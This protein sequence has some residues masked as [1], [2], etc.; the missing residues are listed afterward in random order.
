MKR[1]S[2]IIS[3][4]ILMLALCSETFA[5]PE[6]KKKGGNDDAGTT[7]TLVTSGTGDTK[8]EATKNALRSALEQTYGAFVSSNTQVVNDELVKDEIV[9]ISTGNIVSYE[10]LS[11]IDSNP[12]QVTV[13]AVVSITRLQSYAQNK[14]MSAELAGNTFAMNHKMEELNKKNQ[15]IALKHLLEQ[16]KLMS[17]NL[18]DYELSLGNPEKSPN[19]VQVPVTIRIKANENTVS[20][21]DYFH[22][23]LTSIAVQKKTG[24]RVFCSGSQ[25]IEIG[26]MDEF[27]DKRIVYDLRGEARDP[28]TSNTVYELC[29][30]IGEAVLNCELVDNLGNVSGFKKESNYGNVTKDFVTTNKLSYKYHGGSGRS[31]R[32]R[33]YRDGYKSFYFEQLTSVGTR[34]F[35]FWLNA[36]KPKVGEKL[37]ETK[38]FLMYTVD[39]ISKISKIEI[40]PKIK[41]ITYND[42]LQNLKSVLKKDAEK[43]M[44]DDAIKMI[45]EADKLTGDEKI[46]YLESKESM[47]RFLENEPYKGILGPEVMKRISYLKQLIK[48]KMGE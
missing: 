31:D 3:C 42:D 17:Q 10:E 35:Y 14:G 32:L 22:K 1:F 40:R 2:I 8:E 21:Y 12:K 44:S 39:E 29:N 9:S 15:D 4:I 48:Q 37:Y 25:G 46:E 38:L 47:L 33:G 20:F 13:S 34:G 41:N 11:Y 19:G 5:S 6:K 26:G 23:T 28:N 18:F 27:D 16:T 7:I 45:N 36:L 24:G 30:V 43:L